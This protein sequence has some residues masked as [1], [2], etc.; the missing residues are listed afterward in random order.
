MGRQELVS[1]I[2]IFKLKAVE[3]GYAFPDH[4]D[5][6]AIS[7]D[8]LTNLFVNMSNFIVENSQ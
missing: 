1:A 2:N 7:I 5:F 6:N 4:L 8:E 3:L